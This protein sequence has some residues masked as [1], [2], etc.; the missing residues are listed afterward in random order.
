MQ[1]PRLTWSGSPG[2]LISLRGGPWLFSTL[3]GR[4]VV[5]RTRERHRFSADPFRLGML[6]RHASGIGAPSTHLM[7]LVDLHIPRARWAANLLTV[8][9][10]GLCSEARILMNRLMIPIWLTLIRENPTPELLCYRAVT[11]RRIALCTWVVRFLIRE[12]LTRHCTVRELVST[13]RHDYPA[14]L[15]VPLILVLTLDR[16]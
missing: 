9:C 5:W 6:R 12:F 2:L 16:Y 1:L 7:V 10:G 4:T 11:I 15:G 14:V 8:P 13:L 3:L